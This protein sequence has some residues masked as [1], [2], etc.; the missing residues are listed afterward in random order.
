[1]KN[2]DIIMMA[3]WAGFIFP[4]AIENL[5]SGDI[6]TGVFGCLIACG[7]LITSFMIGKQR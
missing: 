7:A 1:M 6:A 3:F 4:I 2:F 5:F